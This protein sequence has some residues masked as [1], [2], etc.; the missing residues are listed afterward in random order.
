[1]SGDRNKVLYVAGFGR[2]GSTLLVDALRQLNGLVSVGGT[3]G[4]WENDLILNKLCSCR[5]PF[6]Y[7]TWRQE[8][9]RIFN[10]PVLVRYG[11]P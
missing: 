3:C 2:S 8:I 9:E 4:T 11:Y 10:F 6:P 1:M 7:K 5:I